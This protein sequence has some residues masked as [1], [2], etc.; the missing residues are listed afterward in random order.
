R[1]NWTAASGRANVP[2]GTIY[3]IVSRANLVLAKGPGIAAPDAVTQAYN[4][5]EAKFLR[6]Y[7]YLRLTKAYD[8]VPLLLS[9]EEQANPSPTRAPVE[10]VHQ[11]VIQDLTEAE[12]SLP[13]VWRGNDGYGIPTQGRA[14]KGAAQMALADLYAWRSSFMSK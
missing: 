1:L 7:A 4:L 13:A 12:V 2:F 8:G 6:G 5:A 14:T 11:A 10:Q 3:G 9:P